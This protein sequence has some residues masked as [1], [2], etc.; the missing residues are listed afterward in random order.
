MK[1]RLAELQQLSKNLTLTDIADKLAEEDDNTS[2]ED[3]L[4]FS[5]DHWDSVETFLSRVNAVLN[6]LREMESL[7]E[8]IKMKHSQILIEPGVHP[9]FTQDLNTA[10]KDFKVKSYSTKAAMQ[11]MS[12]EVAKINES[13]NPGII[14]GVDARIKRNQIMALT[15]KFQNV[16][17]AFNDEQMVYKD[18]CKQKIQ[19]YLSLS[20]QKI[21]DDDIEKAIEDGQLFD[22]TKGLILAQRDKKAL[23]D[24]VKSRHED[25]IRLEASI[26]ELRNLFQDMSLLLESQGEMLNHIEKNVE[27]AVDCATKAFNNVKQARHMQKNK[28]KMKIILVIVVIIAILILFGILSTAFCTFLP[29][30]CR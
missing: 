4:L 27:S 14:E 20:G 17:L 5:S 26:K 18:K 8:E 22:Y 7:L 25:I 9:K 16:L 1:D 12:D 2:A 3:P 24:E 13:S 29:F 21:S 6:E 23:Y 28:R 11:Q 19:S 15:R 10:I 30:L